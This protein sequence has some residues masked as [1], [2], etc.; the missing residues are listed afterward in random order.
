MRQWVKQPLA[1]LKF[2]TLVLIQVLA[3]RFPIQ[4][5][6][7]VPEKPADDAASAQSAASRVGDPDGVPDSSLPPDLALAV[8]VIGGVSQW[9]Q[10]LTLSLFP[11]SEEYLVQEGLGDEFPRPSACLIQE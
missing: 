1:M 8:A 6:V 7:N 10:D 5:S 4:P 11:G 3:A 2:H 9:I